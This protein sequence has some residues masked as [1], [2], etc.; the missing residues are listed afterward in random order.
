M[1]RMLRNITFNYRLLVFVKKNASYSYVKRLLNAFAATIA[2]SQRYNQTL[3]DFL[4]LLACHTMPATPPASLDAPADS[5]PALLRLMGGFNLTIQGVDCSH[6]LNY[7][8]VRL[9]L[10]VLALAQ[11]RPVTRAQLAAM[12][13]P[14]TETADGRSRVRHALHTLR[15]AFETL[16]EALEADNTR[17][18]LRTDMVQVDVLSLLGDESTPFRIDDPQCL[19]WY[20]GPLLDSLNLPPSDTVQAWRQG[21]QARIEIEMAQ[22]RQR[23]IERY[24]QENDLPRAITDTKRWI[25]QW[26]E[27]EAC[28]RQ[29]IRLLLETGQ[30]EAAML[31]FEHCSRI[32]GERLGVPPS[33]ETQ[34]LL[35]L[36]PR[37]AII[38][39]TT[40]TRHHERDFRPLAI[41]A[42]TLNWRTPTRDAEL[43]VEILEQTRHAISSEIQSAGAWSAPASGN[44][45]LAYFGYPELVERPIENAIDLA[46]RLS[47]LPMHES[48][49]IGIGLHADI[50]LTNA[51]K[52]P[53]AAGLMEQA[54]TPLSW[55]ARHREILLSQSALQRL[56]PRQ[57]I[58]LK[59]AGRTDHVLEHRPGTA[60]VPRLHGRSREF[61]HLAQQWMR[62]LPG[63]PPT[64]IVLTGF[65]GIGK[66]LLVD[67]LAE[68]AA[69]TEGH[70]LRLECRDAW[71]AQPLQPMLHWLRN[72]LEAGSARLPE[73]SASTVTE[74]LYEQFG[75]KPG[76]AAMIDALLQSSIRQPIASDML[77]AL[78]AALLHEAVHGGQPRLIV[79]ENLQWADPATLALLRGL[80]GKPQRTP[81]ML[82]GT[83]R[84]QPADDLCQTLQLGPLNEI[85]MAQFVMHRSRQ[86]KLSRKQ[87]QHV[88]QLSHGVPLY[89]LQLMRQ[90]AQDLP[91]DHSSSLTDTLCLVLR[92]LDSGTQEIAQLILLLDERP[93][94]ATLGR[95]LALSSDSID[96]ALVRLRH[97]GILMTA[98]DGQPECPVL[99]RL[100]LRRTVPR[101]TAQRL[102]ALIARHMID[103]DAL[104]TRIAPH[105]EQADD[106]ATPLWWQRAARQEILERQPRR[107]S[108][109]LERAL[110]HAHRIDTSEARR[111][112]EFECQL[113]LGELASATTGP[114]AAQTARAYEAASRLAPA[115]NANAALMG[116]WGQWI[117]SQHT[118]R[119]TEALEL[120]RRHLRVALD[121]Q[122]P[123]AEGWAHYAI[124][125][126]YLWCGH[127]RDAEHAL[128]QSIAILSAVPANDGSN[129]YGQHAAALTHAT[130]ALCQA[131]QG[132]GEQALLRCQAAIQMAMQSDAGV[133]LAGC[134]LLCAR[135]HY[136]LED[137]PAAAALCQGLLPYMPATDQPD[138]WQSLTRAYAALPRALDGQDTA[139]LEELQST[140]PVIQAGMPTLLNSQLCLVARALIAHRQ[141]DA[142]QALLDQADEINRSQS[143]YTVEPEIQ[144]LRGDIWLASGHI[145]QACRAWSLAR[146][147]ALRHGLLPYVCWADQR[148]Q[149]WPA[150][151]ELSQPESATAPQ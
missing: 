53:D 130:L 30:R 142:A 140:L 75:L 37:Q 69:K 31:A 123:E 54:A 148:I 19:S 74:R 78:G 116:L 124:G 4:D 32:L 67:A 118:G 72:Q 59:R 25:E 101:R 84:Q 79:V 129:I 112:F 109:S 77:E 95:I 121:L 57:Y 96:T 103:N 114:G 51:D 111:L 97:D 34:A 9:M 8:K 6:R 82:L 139:A 115:D 17:I 26:P 55:Q 56:P 91:L 145:Q 52:H 136:L 61:D 141:F 106:P 44:T 93:D 62:L 46:R 104:A 89:A 92:Q 66:S 122:H 134:L 102:H 68:Y 71:R 70:C 2:S 12:I 135:I 108:A 40:A 41:V 133:T 105:M 35:G 22:C 151:D 11:A 80:L 21:W 120:A 143:S 49:N 150:P 88:M 38:V 127:L 132:Q 63:R 45:L 144:C 7:D 138:P 87:R 73:E 100:A 20:R 85:D 119:Y 39:T 128:E 48:V 58:T 117:V 10:A 86:I 90:T 15:Q 110:S 107:A 33:P 131:L 24:V 18:T 76:Q 94:S 47:G 13:W 27:D 16:P 5:A 23:L 42:V 125:Q 99:V 36:T 113:F 50:A 98:V 3:T 28:H 83:S 146:E 29:L 81:L 65:A 64:G 14:D 60:V 149:K 1:D 147:N 126:T 43:A 137:I